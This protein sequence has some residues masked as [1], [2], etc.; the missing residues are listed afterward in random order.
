MNGEIKDVWPNE[1]PYRHRDSPPPPPE[2]PGALFQD[3][4]GE[5]FSWGFS[6]GPDGV[7]YCKGEKGHQ[8][9]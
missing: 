3:L 6:S 4:L 8:A 1:S 5:G 9:P 7:L 2:G